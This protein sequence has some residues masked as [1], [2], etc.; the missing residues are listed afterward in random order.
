[1]NFS[2]LIRC[3]VA[4]A[5][6]LAGAN[7]SG[8]HR[9]N[10]IAAQPGSSILNQVKAV[11]AA[12]KWFSDTI[13]VTG[14]LVPRQEAIVALDEGARLT[15]VLAAE[16][17][18]V[19]AGQPLARAARLS[20]D[21]QSAAGG[22]LS[23]KPA[24]SSFTLNAPAAGL[25]TQ[26]SASI[27]S[28]PSPRGEPL[29]RI[30]INEEI[31][32]AADVPSIHVPALASGQTART[33]L[34]DGTNLLGAVRLVPAQIDRTTQLGQARVSVPQDPALRVGMFARATI[35]ASQ[36]YGISVPREAISYQTE[37]TSVQIVRDG[38][39]ETRRV[40]LGLSSDTSVEISQG[41]NEGDVVVADSGT[42]LHDGDRV[43]PDLAEE[44]DN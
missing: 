42:S 10:A 33:T 44:T 16:G 21:G 31:E 41:L 11:L 14:I 35:D 25:V 5:A 12:K 39:V 17:D 1:M 4:A 26:S 36:S 9:G 43:Q 32:L 8:P 22:A 34:E 13:H 3:G 7:L 19:N 40:R 38:T 6:F 23:A 27:G 30:M 20:P 29:F 15:E 37:G 2:V 28:V 18:R 24:S